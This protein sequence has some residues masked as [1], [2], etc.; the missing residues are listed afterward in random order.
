ML[1][2]AASVAVG[3][4]T[5]SVTAENDAPTFA[6]GTLSVTVAEDTAGA[7]PTPPLTVATDVGDIDNVLADLT[8]MLLN[9]RSTPTSV[10]LDVGD[11]AIALFA[12]A[13][14]V[15]L[16]SSGVGASVIVL[17]D[18]TLNADANGVWTATVLLSD[19]GA[20]TAAYGDGGCGDDKR[21]GGE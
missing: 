20:S 8:V 14:T 12:T 7:V 13:P 2:T 1:P 4:V 9:V 17:Q 5:I 6:A 3:V 21:D 19:G 10:G 15:S 16:E 11:A 18:G